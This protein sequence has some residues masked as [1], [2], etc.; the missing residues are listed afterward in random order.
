MKRKQRKQL[1][2][3]EFVSAFNKIVHYIREHTRE[4]MA[5]CALILVLVLIVFGV[6]FISKQ[7]LKKENLILAEILEL[8]SDLDSKPENLAR[9]EELAGRGKF[10]RLGYLAL[11]SYW[12]ENGDLDKAQGYLEEI[13]Q[14]QKDGVYYQGQDLLAQVHFKKKEYDKAIEIY[15]SIEEDDPVSFALDIVLFHR[16]E[17]HEGKG[18]TEEALVLY[19]KIQEEY[20]QTYYGFDASQKVQKL[21]A[22]K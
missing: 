7:N 21:E 3:D 1:K 13:P 19:R 14:K 9:L 15:R 5:F 16:A 11:A 10:S 22:K 12:I 2:E 6:R 4:L 8:R 20:S 18:E 17:V